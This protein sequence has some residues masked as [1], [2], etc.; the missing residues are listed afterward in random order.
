MGDLRQKDLGMPKANPYCKID[1]TETPQ[2][3]I[4]VE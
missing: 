4:V 3:F 2:G 1:L